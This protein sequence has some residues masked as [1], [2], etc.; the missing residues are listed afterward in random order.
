MPLTSTWIASLAV[1][2]AAM[3]VSLL[4]EDDEYN[5]RLSPDGRWLAYV[6]RIPQREVFVRPMTG[7]GRWQVSTSGGEEPRWSSDGRTLYY[8][9]DNVL[10]AVAVNAGTAF[11][12]SVPMQVLKGIFNLRSESGISYEVDSNADRFL[13]LRLGDEAADSLSLRVITN[14]TKDLPEH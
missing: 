2:K 3:P 8:R 13:M 12:S 10:M 5:G 1:Q 9:N 7:S 14:W 6:V 4:N 11:E